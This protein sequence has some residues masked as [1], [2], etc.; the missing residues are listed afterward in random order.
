METRRRELRMT[1]DAGLCPDHRLKHPVSTGIKRMTGLTAAGE[2]QC[3][4]SP[5]AD[6]L[7]TAST[8]ERI[9]K[10]QHPAIALMQRSLSSPAQ[11]KINLALRG[12]ALGLLQQ[13]SIIAIP[14]RIGDGSKCCWMG[15]SP[16]EEIEHQQLPIPP[17][18]GK[19]DQTAK[20][21]VI[22][23]CIGP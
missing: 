11:P 1:D 4:R 5:C 14:N 20:G 15:R 16:G 18:L 2:T 12:P 13:N 7:T 17:A 6:A 8:P 22:R 10:L 21:R 3:Q 9:Q 19:T 23:P